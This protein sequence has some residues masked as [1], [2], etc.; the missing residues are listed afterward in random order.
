[1]KSIKEA[2]ASANFERLRKAHREKTWDDPFAG[3]A[4]CKACAVTKMPTRLATPQRV[5]A[6]PVRK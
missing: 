4:I 3:E 1:L 5:V 6:L 2:W